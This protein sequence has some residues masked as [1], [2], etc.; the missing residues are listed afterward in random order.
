M[1]YVESSESRKYGLY[2][3]NIT[4]NTFSI[5]YDYRGR[6][7]VFSNKTIYNKV[8]NKYVTEYIDSAGETVYGYT[9]TEYIAPNI[10]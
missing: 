2:Q 9:E 4:I 8:L 7:F 5:S 6:R 1:A 3:P 10:I